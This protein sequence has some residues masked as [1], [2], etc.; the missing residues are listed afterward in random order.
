MS[1]LPLMPPPSPTASQLVR[2]AAA[3]LGALVLLDGVWI[4]LVAPRL[5]VDFV[6]KIIPKIQ[7]TPLKAKI[8]PALLAYTSMTA[9]VVR[10]AL[11]RVAGGGGGPKGAALRAA[12]T[13]LYVYSIFRNDQRLHVQCVADDGHHSGQRVGHCPIWGGRGGSGQGGGLGLKVKAS[14]AWW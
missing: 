7:G 14:R 10:S 1:S 2:A 8:V 4:P 13:G 6:N 3:A 5:G 12:E 11:R 9:A